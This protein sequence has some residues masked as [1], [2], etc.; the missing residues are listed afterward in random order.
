MTEPD[1]AEA[2]QA[3]WQR[4]QSLFDTLVELP[5]AEQEMA[6][7]ALPRDD[8]LTNEIRE[9]LRA[10]ARSAGALDRDLGELSSRLIADTPPLEEMIG[11]YRLRS[12]LGEGGMG[13]VY[14]AEREDLER[15][16]ALKILLDGGLSPSRRERFLAE[17]RTLAQLSH[18]A[19]AQ[20]FD[21]GT[22]PNGSPWFAMEYVDGL[23]LVEYCRRNELSLTA[24]LELMARICEAVQH[25][26]E[27]AVV[28]RDLK[29]SNILITADGQVKLLDFGIAKQLDATT[30]TGA[31]ATQPALRMLTPAYAAPEQV[32]GAPVGVYTDVYALG[33]LVFQLVTDQLP[34]RSDDTLPKRAST[35][36]RQ[37]GGSWAGAASSRMG[38][39]I[40][41][42]CATAMHPDPT[43]RYR[44]AD[45]LRR[46]LVHTLRHEPLEA[47]PE[48]AWYRLQRFGARN[49]TGVGLAAAAVLLI[50]TG[51][52][53]AVQRIR[54]ARDAAE[55]ELQRRELMQQFLLGLFTGEEA[56]AAPDSLRVT[57][58]IDRG[59]QQAAML[60]RDPRL[61][62]E[63]LL[64][65]GRIQLS[66][67]RFGRADST[68]R[69]AQA[70]LAN[71]AGVAENVSALA[72]LAEV[73]LGDARY[74]DA[75]SLLKAATR[76][77]SG[78]MG[79]SV[80]EGR[81]RQLTTQLAETEGRRQIALGRYDSA[82]TTLRIALSQLGRPDDEPLARARIL[83]D[84]ADVAFYQGNYVRADSLNELV[85]R[86]YQQTAGARHPRVAATLVN[87]GATA[88]EQ[89][90][91][92]TAESR[93]RDALAIAEGYFGPQHV[94]VASTRTML[95]RALVFEGRDPEAERE[96]LLALGIQ[97]AALGERHP[98]V[99]G[100]L[101]ELGNIAIRRKEFDSADTLF[102]RMTEVYRATNGDS[103]FTV[104]VALS[105]RGTV[106][107]QRKDL[108]SAERIFRDVVRRFAAAQGPK[109]M[110]TGIARIKL[111]RALIQQSRW[112]E[113]LRESHAGHDIV[114]SQA[115]PGISFLQA[116]RRDMA[117]AWRAL[118]E[119]ARAD[120][121]VAAAAAHDSKPA[122]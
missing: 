47:H 41:L 64:A 32:S 59:E 27:H 83:G 28:H 114:A 10:D 69:N 30:A 56:G 108:A 105:N 63:L 33:V 5:P 50:A 68:V 53:V 106:A 4:M 117:L 90:H 15:P 1:A 77:L 65:L 75:D 35:V 8:E 84:L 62:G 45:A 73:R 96:L 52:S 21:A 2:R 66:L 94:Q 100:T 3:R 110:N 81:R 22:L 103:H 74:P 20:L 102:A 6:L 80:S 67:G 98:S 54:T 119:P 14:L 38:Q 91:Y 11:P 31:D 24:R 78:N 86:D 42:L 26:H 7:N 93:Y 82:A 87:L 92:S 113:G 25:A 29:P 121:L 79:R 89:G 76:I 116:S 44:T 36:M 39:D 120:S 101:N 57:T 60:S 55:S 107:M 72:T 122:K 48:S 118:G 97:R 109:H 70:A 12:L 17:R 61:Q 40:D 37:G 58:A 34:D 19:V 51:T 13:V 18:P 111:G 115:A 71:A 16:V 104:A 88:F 95:G 99:A 43:R 9:L 85:L 23:P 49:R 46:D 112:Q